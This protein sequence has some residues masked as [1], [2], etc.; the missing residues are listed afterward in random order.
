MNQIARVQAESMG[1]PILEPVEADGMTRPIAL[2][3]DVCIAGARSE[4][5]LK[6]PSPLVSRTHAIFVAD[7]DSIYLRD[8]ASRNHTYLNQEPIREAVLRN[9][10]V[11]GLGPLTFR[12]KSGF[13]KPYDPT[14]VHAP[15]AELRDLKSDARV[16]LT[17]RSTLIG[18]RRDCDVVLPGDGVEPS[19]AIIFEREGRRYIRDLRTVSG[20]WVNDVA[21]GQVELD[22]GDEIRVGEARYAFQF[23]SADGAEPDQE[24]MEAAAEASDNASMA[25][26][27][28]DPLNEDP[29]LESLLSNVSNEGSASQAGAEA[30]APP[31]SQ[32]GDR[33][34]LETVAPSAPPA[35]PE[36]E[37]EPGQPADDTG[38]PLAT[39]DSVELSDEPA[40][41]AAAAA[42]L[43][44]DAAPSPLSPTSFEALQEPELRPATAE[45][46]EVPREEV[47]TWEAP[48]AEDVIPLT[49]I[50]AVEIQPEEPSPKQET[51]V[52]PAND[53]P[54]PGQRAGVAPE[55]KMTGLLG[56]LAGNIAEVKSTWEAIRAKETE[57]PA[58]KN[59]GT[60]TGRESDVGPESS[61]EP[62]RKRGGAARQHRE[63]GPD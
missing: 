3:K 29:A 54:H 7:R 62:G 4:V 36:P 55:E 52:V 47:A 17:S 5:N 34:P 13:D 12:C 1:L 33:L 60:A 50:P 10:D 19:H 15:A 42:D 30:E 61:G 37:P 8:L 48:P 24:A 57:A 46:A 2:N 44:L 25:L 28:N 23:A 58:G 32:E 45:V 22:P 38:I 26:E 18:S 43:D 16:P 21:A 31:E 39:E 59:P 9:G 63:S 35:Q 20:T 41:A 51:G 40:P 53:A 14:E 27:W 56:E 6:L 49:A 11:I